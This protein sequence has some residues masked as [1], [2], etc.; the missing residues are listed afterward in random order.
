MSR[1]GGSAS[2][3]CYAALRQGLLFATSAIIAPLSFFAIV[4]AI[5]VDGT[6]PRALRHAPP[7][8]AQAT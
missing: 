1:I 8:V 5:D 6:S 7:R 2:Q 4:V 3:P